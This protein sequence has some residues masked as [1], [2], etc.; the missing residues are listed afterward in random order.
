MSGTGLTEKFV[1][2][3]GLLRAVQ[4]LSLIHIWQ[5]LN[6]T[7]EVRN[8]IVTHTKGTWAATP[9]GRIVRMADQI[10]YVDV[11]KRQRLCHP[12]RPVSLPALLFRP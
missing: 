11:Y 5:G 12:E 8:G 2:N 1:Q 6:L 3:A 7:W 4:A 9:E 10:A